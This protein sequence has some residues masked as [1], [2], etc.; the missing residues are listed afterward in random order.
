MRKTNKWLLRAVVAFILFAVFWPAPKSSSFHRPPVTAALSVMEVEP[1]LIDSPE[2]LPVIKQYEENN[3]V[4]EEH[5]KDAKLDNQMLAVQVKTLDQQAD[6]I[7]KKIA[8]QRP[9]NKGWLY[10]LFSRKK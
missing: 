6:T 9:T 5:I 4:M 10:R 2:L 7:A 1:S 3:K 8:S